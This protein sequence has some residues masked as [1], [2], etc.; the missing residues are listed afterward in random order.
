M[1]KSATPKEIILQLFTCYNLQMIFTLIFELQN[2]GMSYGGH[3][4]FFPIVQM[5]KDRLGVLNQTFG[6]K[7]WLHN[8]QVVRFQ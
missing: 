6:F 4:I 1:G 3:S 2:S 7:F 5:K 8:L